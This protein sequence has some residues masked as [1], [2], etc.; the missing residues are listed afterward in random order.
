MPIS[1][2]YRRIRILQR[3]E[4]EIRML[5]E[6]YDNTWDG[7]YLEESWALA[8]SLDKLQRLHRRLN[9][10]VQLHTERHGR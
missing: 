7:G 5:D 8:D 9:E 6:A 3:L 10:K 2:Q 4:D 1:A